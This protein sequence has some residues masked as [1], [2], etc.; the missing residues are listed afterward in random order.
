MSDHAKCMEPF[1]K[2]KHRQKP[3]KLTRIALFMMLSAAVVGILLLLPN[4]GQLSK[5]LR[6]WA[7]RDDADFGTF[8]NLTDGI[9][10]AAILQ[11]DLAAANGK[12]LAILSPDGTQ[13]FS[14]EI[15][16]SCP[17]LTSCGKVALLWD[18]GG[19]QLRLLTESE[20]IATTVT[21]ALLYADVS[22]S[23]FCY[24][25]ILP[26]GQC[27]LTARTLYGDPVFCR[28]FSAHA[29]GPCAISKDGTQLAVATMSGTD[30]S[31]C[32]QVLLLSAQGNAPPCKISLADTFVQALGFVGED[33]LC[34]ISDHAAAVFSTDGTQ[35]GEC[36]RQE[37]M[38]QSFAICERGVVLALQSGCLLSLAQDGSL[39]A[40]TQLTEQILDVSANGSYIA[41]ATAAGVSVYDRDLTSCMEQETN[42]PKKIFVRRDGTVIV[43]TAE[44]MQ[45]Y[46]FR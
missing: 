37:D 26:D 36:R 42:S 2:T 40:Q 1:E 10:A 38:V 27:Q 4:F 33:A 16:M 12:E 23:G 39:R 31:F 20:C 46:F 6:Y 34:V 25:A 19:N 3:G 32:T 11:D 22:E 13:K 15:R 7:V 14:A 43:Q 41:V 44:Q 5:P 8:L 35:R 30:G 9:A 17:K 21:G 18:V 29:I 45:L 24:T 28:N